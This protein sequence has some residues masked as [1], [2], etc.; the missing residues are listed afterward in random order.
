M[1]NTQPPEVV[2]YRRFLKLYT[3]L[4]SK[5]GGV[6]LETPVMLRLNLPPQHLTTFGVKLPP[7][8]WM[9]CCR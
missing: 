9:G 1:C 5:C 6:L 3:R 2:T 8:T 4:F 7:S